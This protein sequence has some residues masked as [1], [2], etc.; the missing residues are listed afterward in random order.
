MSARRITTSLVAAGALA[1]AAA[2]AGPATAATYP[3]I[4]KV[5]PMEVKIGGTLTLTGKNF[6][7]GKGKNT[8]VFRRPGKR[9]IFVNG[10]G[11]STTRIRVV[12]PEK[13]APFLGKRD[14]AAVASKFQLN[15]LTRR[16]GRTYTALKASPTIAPA[17]TPAPAPA[18]PATTPTATPAATGPATPAGQPAAQPQPSTP[19]VEQPTVPLDTDGD[20]TPDA[21]DLDDDNDLL[22]DTVEKA[23]GTSPTQMDTDGDGME[24]GWEYQSAADLNR[25]SCPATGGEYPQPCAGIKP[26]PT[27]KQYPN[28]LFPDADGDYDNDY[29]PASFEYRAWRDHGVRSLVDMWYSDGMQA[30]RDSNPN[31]GCR[32]LVEQL[33]TGHIDQ[34]PSGQLAYPTDRTAA[35]TTRW[36]WL[37]A[38]PEYT[39]D[40]EAPLKVGHGC[41]DD[42]E[43]DEDGD[44]LS[45]FIELNYV[46]SGPEF[47]QKLWKEPAFKTIYDGT[48]ALDP[49]TDGDGIVDGMDDQDFDDFWNVE[50][51]YRGTPSAVK[52]ETAG[53]V[54][55]WV[56]SGSRTGLW[57][58]PFNPCL[59][60]IYARVCARTIQ[61]DEEP[62]MPFYD[63]RDGTDPKYWPYPRW[64][65]FETSVYPGGGSGDELWGA[66]PQSSQILPLRQP[67][68]PGP[69]LQHPLLPRPY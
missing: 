6:L 5:S 17:A 38:R 49:D 63:E 39:L 33:G 65:L 23:I 16:F 15:V 4:S 58:D 44:F 62:W 53:A 66:Y 2:T 18:T 20:G 21:T 37:Y 35:P 67:G 32:G 43:R 52:N 47:V 45:N 64:P 68:K 54:I 26:Y 36:G 28:P 8:V 13:L 25:E 1:A 69:G 9:S 61:I 7:K 30:S 34:Y 27:K 14:G 59:P 29:L 42:G 56:D 40:T 55:P 3:S 24:D 51:I 11:L 48:D 12:V 57:V 31:D 46:L 50:E 19:T 41:L 60:A 10:D 22:P